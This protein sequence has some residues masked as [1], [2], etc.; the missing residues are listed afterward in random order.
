MK[1]KKYTVFLILILFSTIFTS[2]FSLNVFAKED[3]VPDPTYPGADPNTFWDF[4]ESDVVGW[5]VRKFEGIN[6]ASS[7]DYIYNTTGFGYENLTVDEEY[8]VSYFF[9]YVN[10]TQMYFNITLGSLRHNTSIPT[11][12]TSI[13]NYTI[14]AL[15]PVFGLSTPHV[16]YFIPKNSTGLHLDY[17]AQLMANAYDQMG[18]IKDPD[19]IDVT[20]NEITIENSTSHNYAHLFYFD[21]GTLNKGEFFNSSANERFNY[22]RTYDFDPSDDVQW[23]FDSGETVGWKHDYHING[24][25]NKTEV[26]YYNISGFVYGLYGGDDYYYVNLSR[27]YFNLTENTLKENKTADPLNSSVV[28]SYALFPQWNA[29]PPYVPYFIPKNSTGLHL[30]YHAQL[31]ANF[32]D[33]P[34]WLG[35]IEDPDII[36]NNGE[37]H[38]YIANTTTSEYVRLYYYNN[39]TLRT[40]S[41]GINSS[42]NFYT[43]NYTRTFDF[44][45]ID[46]VQWPVEVG[47]VLYARWD[48][49]LKAEVVDFNNTYF[50]GVGVVQE[51][52]ANVSK[53]DDAS[54]WVLHKE[55]ETI[56]R[57]NDYNYV[58]YEQDMNPWVFRIGTNGTHLLNFIKDLSK[59]PDITY[60]YGDYWGRATNQTSGDQFHMEIFSNQ[61]FKYLKLTEYNIT[62]Y[63]M[64]STEVTDKSEFEIEPYNIEGFTINANISVSDD[65]LAMYAA[66][67][68]NPGVDAINNE[69]L[70]MDILLNNSG[71]L[72]TLNFTIEFDTTEYEGLKFWW[73]NVSANEGDGAWK[74][75]SF[76]TISSGKIFISMNHT[77]FYAI[78]A[79]EY[80]PPPSNPPGSF[81]LTTTAGSPD[82]DGKITLN[83][84]DSANADSYILYTYS[85][86]ITEVNSSL[87]VVAD[88][89]T[90]KSYIIDDLTNG[91]YYYAVLAKNSDGQELSNSVK[92][93]VSISP[94][95]GDGD[96]DGDDDDD[97]GAD[98][99]D[100]TT[101]PEI[102]FGNSYLI[103]LLIGLL[104]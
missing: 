46:E 18:W 44:N 7:K 98:G 56:G 60:S 103:F 102:P 62:N 94:E 69:R 11:L 86:N 43:H 100:G 20:G 31:F 27:Y 63:M 89:L 15:A 65:T 48:M 17:Y 16:P 57:A 34:D 41:V 87:T 68:N 6:L 76:E 101:P 23:G 84:T 81:N 96:D 97:D 90:N 75:I 54:G 52:I 32:L 37:D 95:G 79:A 55:N 1:N 8:D 70:F 21:N 45:P 49:N 19:Y 36:A 53:W 64:N 14:P 4:N 104:G 10:L 85:K 72:D 22:T 24:S 42:G 28:I 50:E 99:G 3:L 51:V 29:I 30:D 26:L 38:I 9:Y 2:L 92:V 77:S 59:G 80:T 78:S 91:T 71:T 58:I 82:A 93:D 83:W 67:D 66:F 61:V 40:A 73:Y 39:G 33:E 35:Y 25:L 74:E 13:L 88:G 5:N 12:R 47:D